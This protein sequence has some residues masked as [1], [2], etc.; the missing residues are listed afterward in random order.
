MVRAA[1]LSQPRKP[2]QCG[3]FVPN[4]KTCSVWLVC[5]KRENLLSVAGLSQ[6]RKCFAFL[7]GQPNYT[8]DEA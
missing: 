4:E 1:G 2:A 7:I 6:P 3:S 8:C 5:P